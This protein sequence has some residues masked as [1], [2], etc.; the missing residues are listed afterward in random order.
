METVGVNVNTIVANARTDELLGESQRLAAELQARSEELQV[1]A[2]G[3]P[4]LQ[5]RAGGE[6]RAAGHARTATSRR[7]TWRSSRP[8]RNWRPAPSSWRCA[9]KY[10]SE[11]LAN[12]SHELR[13]PL[14]S[15]LILAQ[16]LAQN[17]TRNLTA[18]QVE[19]AGII[20]SAGLRP[21]PAD[22]RHPRPVQG[23]GRQDGHHP[24]AGLAA[25]AAGLRRGHVPAADHAEEPGASGSTT[26]PGVPADL[27]TDDSRLRQ[28]LRNLLSNAVKFTEEGGVELRIEPAA[29]TGAARGGR[30]RTA[31]PSPSGSPTPASASAEQQLGDDLRR[32]PAG[33]R[34]HQPQVRRHR[35]GPV[36]QPR[37]R[38]PA[39]RRDHR[40]SST[41][42]EGSTF[43]LYLPVARPDFAA[44][45]TPG[46]QPRRGR[47]DGRRPGR[48][49]SRSSG[50]P[51]QQRRLLVI[52]ERPH[53]LLSLVAESAVADLADAR[54]IGTRGPVEVVT[55]VGAEEA[56][57]AL[58]ARRLPLRGAGPGPAGATPA[59]RFLDA[60]RRRRRAARGARC[61][62][63]TAAGSAREQEQL[64]Q[65]R[66]DDPAA[67]AAVQPGRAARA[68]RAAP[69]RR[70]AR[71]RAAA[72]P[73]RHGHGS[74]VTRRA[75]STAAGR[76]HGAGRRRRHPQRLRAH[77]HPG[78]ARHAGAARRERPQGHRGARSRTPTST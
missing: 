60:M 63:T 14:N 18:K 31:R 68:H 70:A 34:H 71:R 75:R 9:S 11:F 15:L 5:R 46:A 20:H 7:R 25:A 73:R 54:T 42:G 6:G 72:G 2:G 58:A 69:D 52:E 39:R 76:A 32:L 1:A 27:L 74:A 29:A 4:A 62:P 19:Y 3:T 30:P 38:L 65:A 21:A 12:M 66:A 40:A 57:A 41:L 53:G 23:R 8:G 35:P 37:D 28:V 26:A 55:A 48:R 67:G 78:T 24:G 77:R 49:G 33:R 44:A 10:K 13:T 56:A 64:L 17:P 47:P 45:R 51:L 16:L 43:T 61:W 59:L 36:D 22:Q 50:W